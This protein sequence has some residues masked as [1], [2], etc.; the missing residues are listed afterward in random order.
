MTA[1]ENKEEKEDFMSVN[2]GLAYNIVAVDVW[3]ILL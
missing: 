2:E 1:E 3:S